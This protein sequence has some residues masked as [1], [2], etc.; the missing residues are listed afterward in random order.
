MVTPTVKFPGERG[1]ILLHE[2]FVGFGYA[3]RVQANITIRFPLGVVP[4][5]A[6]PVSQNAT[7]DDGLRSS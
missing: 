3:V 4:R 7:I 2:I 6:A 5:S 1:R